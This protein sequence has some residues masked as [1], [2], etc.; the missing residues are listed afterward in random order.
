M[1]G[2]FEVK[3]TLR[4]TVSRPISLGV[5]PHPRPK[6]RFLL[7]LHSCF[8]LPLPDGP[9]FIASAMTALKTPIPTVP[10]LLL[11]EYP[12]PQTYVYQAVA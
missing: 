1:R 9:R 5:K 12:L 6:T 2:Y 3:V 8:P 4:P 10:L 11:H 7:L